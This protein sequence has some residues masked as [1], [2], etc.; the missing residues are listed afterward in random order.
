MLVGIKSID[1][2][3]DEM[4]IKWPAMRL[5][6]WTDR[7]ATWVG[8]LMPSSIE[9][10]V[11]IRYEVPYAIE[12]FTAL[13]VQPRVQVLNPLLESHP[14][15]WDGPI[16]HVYRN[17]IEPC[18]PYLCLFDPYRGEWSPGDLLAETTVPWAAS[19][20][21]FYEGWLAVKRWLGPGRHATEEERTS[22]NGRAS[23][24]AKV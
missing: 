3:I 16:P 11:R 8:P 15:Y 20:L 18:L 22:G 24:L 13:A 14:D 2:Q 21:Y 7:S 19:Y 6:D 12:A 1:R 4:A 5:L 9:Y 10:Q 17:S 23:A